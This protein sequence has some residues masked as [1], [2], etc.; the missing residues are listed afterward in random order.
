[1]EPPPLWWTLLHLLQAQAELAPGN[2]VDQHVAIGEGEVVVD[3][4]R[5]SVI[6]LVLGFAGHAVVLLDVVLHGVGLFSRER[7]SAA[8]RLIFPVSPPVQNLDMI[9]HKISLYLSSVGFVSSVG[10]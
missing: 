10:V 3:V 6:L 5:V 4:V 8:V 1:M 9:W 2:G 7:L